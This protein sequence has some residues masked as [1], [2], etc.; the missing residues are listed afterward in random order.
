MFIELNISPISY[1]SIN[2]T[3][4]IIGNAWLFISEHTIKSQFVAAATK[5]FNELT[6]RPL[7]EEATIEGRL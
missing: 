4:S 3:F 6:L 1:Y 7:F 2:A 5:F